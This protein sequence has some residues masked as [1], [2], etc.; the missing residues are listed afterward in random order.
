M[1]SI[2]NALKAVVAALNQ[3][4]ANI[5]LQQLIDQLQRFAEGEEM[6]E[7][8]GP[9]EVFVVNANETMFGLYAR[10]IDGKVTSFQVYGASFDPDGDGDP[11]RIIQVAPGQDVVAAGWG[12]GYV[13]EKGRV[14]AYTSRLG[15]IP[16]ADDTLLCSFELDDNEPIE[17]TGIAIGGI[18]EETDEDGNTRIVSAN[19][20]RGATVM[21]EPYAE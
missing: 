16:A 9:P 11:A 21:R 4:G 17:L 3:H 2:F 7:A 13:A 10:G 19:F 15:A 8:V 5:T 14:G 6:P 12:F 18:R 1:R 20:L